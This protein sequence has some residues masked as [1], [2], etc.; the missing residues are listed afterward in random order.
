MLKAEN[1][2]RKYFRNRIGANCFEAVH[3]ASLE[4]ESGTLTLLQGRSGSG[5]TTLL[6][7]LAGLLNPTDG[8][9]LLEQQDLYS[10]PDPE[11]SRLRNEKISVIPQGRSAVDTLTVMENILL[12]ARLYGKKQDGEAAEQW[13]DILGIADLRDVM[14][15]ELSGGELRRMAIV[16]SLHQNAEV[17]LADE[18]TGDLDNE[19]TEKVLELLRQAAGRGCAVLVVSHEEC[20][21][22]Y[23]DRILRMDAGTLL[24][25]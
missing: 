2:S 19:N 15:S 16:R 7:M 8:K 10:L 11:L 1:V 14:P 24:S 6:H 5:K 13:L 25:P 17:I 12:P 23:A 18:P 4:L 20:A 9:V 22:E 3:P 21:A